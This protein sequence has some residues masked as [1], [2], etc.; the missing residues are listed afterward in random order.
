[1]QWA[2]IESRRKKG[3][4]IRWSEKNCLAL[5]AGPGS[6]SCHYWFDNNKLSSVEWL[7]RAYPDKYRWL[8]EQIDGKPRSEH[9]FTDGIGALLMLE[10]ELKARKKELKNG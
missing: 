3:Q 2:H 1:V 8:T 6:N 9:L 4:L 5:C 10:D 7:K